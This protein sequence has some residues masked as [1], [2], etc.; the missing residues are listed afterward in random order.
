MTRRVVWYFPAKVPERR[1]LGVYSFVIV[2]NIVKIVVF[3]V[4]VFF[5]DHHAFRVIIIIVFIVFQGGNWDI[6]IIFH[7]RVIHK[8]ITLT[9]I[10]QDGISGYTGRRENFRLLGGVLNIVLVLGLVSFLWLFLIFN[11]LLFVAVR[12]LGFLVTV[13]V[14]L[15]LWRLSIL[16][17]VLDSHEAEP[18]LQGHRGITEHGNVLF[19]ARCWSWRGRKC[20]L[21]TT[22]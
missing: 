21:C 11:T 2:G 12:F 10:T 1:F 9:K 14:L 3:V 7:V 18:I 19:G 4:V 20:S 5:F 13:M 15:V 16:P 17:I 8:I 22:P 6:W